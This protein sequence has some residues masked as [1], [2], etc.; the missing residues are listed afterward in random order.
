MV[1]R[2]PRAGDPGPDEFARGIRRERALRLL[3][4]RMWPRLGPL[5]LVHDLLG[6][7]AL[8]TDAARGVLD[9]GEIEALYRPWSDALRRLEAVW[10]E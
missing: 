7:R 1:A 10:I 2:R 4:D 5:E 3:L 8:L 9:P 6:S